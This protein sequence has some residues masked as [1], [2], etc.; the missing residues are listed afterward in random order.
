MIDYF[1]LD[2]NTAKRIANHPNFKTCNVDSCFDA[3]HTHTKVNNDKNIISVILKINNPL[4]SSQ[5][6]DPNRNYK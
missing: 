2:I 3:I 5:K 1:Y 6:N 4:F